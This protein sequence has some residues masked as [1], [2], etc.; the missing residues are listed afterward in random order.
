MA[1]STTISSNTIL[2]SYSLFNAT[3]IKNFIINQLKTG[4]NPIFTNVDYLGSNI[5]AFIDIIAVM[6]QQILFNFSLNASETSFSNAVLY[7]S[8]NKIVSLLSYKP[9]GKQ[10]TMLPVRYTIDISKM[11]ADARASKEEIFIP[12]LSMINYNTPFV[13]KQEISVTI[14]KNATTYNVDSV[15]FEGNINEISP[16]YAVGDEFEVYTLVD[17]N[18]KENNKFISDNFFLV[19]VDINNDGNWEEFTET[20][21]IFLENS[22]A[23]KYEKR[24]NDLYNYEFK[25]GND[26]NGVK[27]KKNSRVA[28]FYIISNGESSILSDGVV[29]DVSLKR[30]TSPLYDEI[31]MSLYNLS[32]SDIGDLQYV[33][34]SNIGQSTSISYPESVESIRT[35]APKIFSSQSRL[36]TISDYKAFIDKNFSTYCKDTF[37]FNN[38]YYTSNYLNYFYEL[39]LDSPQKDSRINIAQVE[40]MSS[41]N[42]NNIYCCALPA[43][44]TII[45]NKV[46]NYLNTI[47]KQEIINT[48]EPYKLFNH[49]LVIIDPIYKACTFGSYNLSSIHYN[50]K[51]LENKLII[52]RDRLSKYSYTWIKDYIVSIFVDFFNSMVLGGVLDVNYLSKA[53]LN[54]PGVKSFLIRD[55]NGNTDSNLTFYVWNP[56]YSN[57]DNYITQQNIINKSFIYTYFYDLNNISNLIQ[58]ED[59]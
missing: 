12:R 31:M 34:V 42:F 52:K 27:L 43:V 41:T 23:R 18:I 5:N 53:I 26:I 28:I 39:G 50:E 19:Y 9:F 21:N 38:D 54:V 20:T 51:Q 47:L 15:M 58:V 25:F 35:N 49:N 3:N 32:T 22:T 17:K 40:F 24:F 14:D 46:P 44:N 57:E 1:V 7:E 13:Q 10:T 37:F 8:M 16:Y 59:E 55:P 33:R 2:N 29:N 36:I 30:Y 45:D 56:L 48:V 4:D 11:A 6:L